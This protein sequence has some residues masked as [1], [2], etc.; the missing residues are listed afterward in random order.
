MAIRTMVA[1]DP[2]LREVAARNLMH[3]QGM[4]A[5]LPTYSARRYA[6]AG[7]ARAQT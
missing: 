3:G 6:R 2:A 1:A 7:A 5:I 4:C